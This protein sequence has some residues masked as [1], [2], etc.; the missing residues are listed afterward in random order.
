M[1][2]RGT[3]EERVRQKLPLISGLPVGAPPDPA[4]EV[5]RWYVTESLDVILADRLWQTLT[6]ILADRLWQTP[7]VFVA[8][9]GVSATQKIGHKIK[10]LPNYPCVQCRPLQ[11]FNKNYPFLL[12]GRH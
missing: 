12:L 1:Q 9:R 5:G 7:C 2:E 6:V 3:R 8:D 4:V 10:L 11:Y